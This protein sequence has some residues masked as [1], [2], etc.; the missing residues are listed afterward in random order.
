[1]TKGHK[2]FLGASLA[3]LLLG[4]PLLIWAQGAGECCRLSQDITVKDFT[5]TPTCFKDATY[6]DACQIGA[7][8][9]DSCN[10]TK[11]NCCDFNNRNTDPDCIDLKKWCEEMFGGG[12]IG[13]CFDAGGGGCNST[14]NQCDFNCLGVDSECKAGFVPDSVTFHKNTVIGGGDLLGSTKDFCMLK[15]EKALIQ[16]ESQ[17]WGTVCL[18]NA[19]YN[20]T[21]WI[22]FFFL[23]IAILIGV[24]A[25]YYFMTSAGDE[26]K[27][28]KARALL[29]YMAIGLVVAALA[30]VIP[31]LVRAVIGI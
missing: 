26:A 13:V 11:D 6:A 29:T 14:N 3:G 23:A 1:M 15:G 17:E 8:D 7:G 20:V 19:I 31:T 12:V 24:I 25:A 18:L 27:I 22:F 9:A 5:Y 21:N 4:L 16:V 10:N 28:S 30:K 2:I